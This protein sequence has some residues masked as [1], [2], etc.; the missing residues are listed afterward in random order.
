LRGSWSSGFIVDPIGI[1][2][3][4]PIKAVAGFQAVSPGFFKTLGIRLR[5]GRLLAS[6]DGPGA[7]PVAVVSEAF[8]PA[9]LGGSDPLGRR[10]RRG[11]QA[12]VI[13]VVGVVSDIRRGG[14]TTV[15]EPQVYLPAAQTQ[16]YPTRLAELAIRVDGEP[17][18]LI[19]RLREAV[20]SV[21]PAQPLVNVRTLDETLSLRQA[22]RQF[23]T[24]LF[25]LFAVLALVLA[26]TGVYSL[27]AYIVSQ[28]TPEIG[29]RIAL[30][31]SGARILRWIVGQSM[32]PLVAGSVAGLVLAILLSERVSALLFDTSPLDP[33]TYLWA[34]AL[35]VV[36]ALA[37]ILAAGWKAVRIDP[38]AVLK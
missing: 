10:F 30:G 28:R 27:A 17:S 2:T 26:V 20:W 5:R 6:D 21:D 15:V 33:A 12:P 34:C 19:P 7:E 9:V 25:G 8:G 3:D 23:H 29:V 31:A 22:E 32:W 16:L 38:V 1:G 18:A 24:L 13:T 36:S 37:A 11:P 14:R 35:L 4:P